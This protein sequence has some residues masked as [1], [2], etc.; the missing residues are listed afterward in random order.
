MLVEELE[1][2][3]EHKE[4]TARAVVYVAGKPQPQIISPI[5]GTRVWASE[6][7]DDLVDQGTITGGHVE[8]FVEGIGWV[9]A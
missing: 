8:V 4:P 3:C 2:L 9:C 6:L 5:G 1:E 7:I